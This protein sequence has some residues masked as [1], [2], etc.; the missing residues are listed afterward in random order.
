MSF[1]LTGASCDD[2]EVFSNSPKDF[3]GFYGQSHIAPECPTKSRPTSK[4]FRTKRVEDSKSPPHKK[5]NQVYA[6]SYSNMR[7]LIPPAQTLV[8]PPHRVVA[9]MSFDNFFLSSNAPKNIFPPTTP[10][11][12]KFPRVAFW[13]KKKPNDSRFVVKTKEMRTFFKLTGMYIYEIE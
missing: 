8:A 2:L 7:A 6:Q 10:K 1:D 3:L 11:K 13:P 12:T 5:L 9:P 4:R